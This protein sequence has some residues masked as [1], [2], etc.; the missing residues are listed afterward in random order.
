MK[1]SKQNYYK[2]FFKNNLKNLKNI[3]KRIRSLIAI[4]HSP[5]S[6]IHMLTYKDAT[7]TYSLHILVQLQKKTV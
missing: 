6:N 5:A 3:W 7:V 1:K 2:Q 4:K